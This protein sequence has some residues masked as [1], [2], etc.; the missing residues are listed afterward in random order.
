M[1]KILGLLI[2]VMVI[3][4]MVI[5]IR[6]KFVPTNEEIIT[7]ARESECYSSKVLYKIINDR[8]INSDEVVLFH[9]NEEDK[10]RFQN[11]REEIYLKDEIITNENGKTNKVLASLDNIYSLAF[12]SNI[13]GKDLESVEEGTEEWGDTRYIIINVNF[14]KS[15]KHISTAKVYLDKK[16]SSPIIINI[17]DENKNK[18]VIIHF[19][20]FEYL[21][22]S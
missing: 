5:W 13:L 14:D 17:Y 18:S 20:D 16:D 12:L 6:Y 21:K 4:G 19:I 9:N 22:N 2:I 7:K 3:I 8:E 15:N 10:I 1:K 11:G